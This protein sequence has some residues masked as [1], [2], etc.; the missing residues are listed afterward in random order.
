MTL[1]A[2]TYGDGRGMITSAWLPTKWF[3]I[4]SAILN[5]NTT[6]ITLIVTPCVHWRVQNNILKTGTL[7]I[8][9][10]V[11]AKW[12]VVI[13]WWCRYDPTTS[14][15]PACLV[16]KHGQPVPSSPSTHTAGSLTRPGSFF[17]SHL[18]WLWFLLLGFQDCCSVLQMA[19]APVWRKAMQHYTLIIVCFA[20][21]CLWTRSLLLLK[22]AQQQ[23]VI[24]FYLK[25]WTE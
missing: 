6:V 22:R 13:H 16:L 2:K 24:N 14:S 1:T 23:D 18:A 8:V 21:T 10:D 7:S 12:V 15:L 19:S 25:N 3:V 20:H 11:C 5:S 4:A 17:C 9:A